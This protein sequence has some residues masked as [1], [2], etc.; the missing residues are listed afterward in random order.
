MDENEQ[1]SRL[2]GWMQR[3]FGGRKVIAGWDW[4]LEKK[5]KHLSRYHSWNQGAYRLKSWLV[6]IAIVLVGLAGLAGLA[7]VGRHHYRHYMEKRGQQQALMF[8]AGGDYRNASLSARQTLTINPN[9]VPACRVQAEMADHNRSPVTLEWLQRIGQI[10]P[11][12]EN[13]L[14]LAAAGLKYQ[15]PPFPLTA[16]ILD[17]LA[18]TATNNATY[19]EV[20]ASFAMYLG[21]LAE[22]EA[23]F[24]KAAA[25]EPK[26]QLF[27][28]NLAVLKMTL[29]NQTEQAQALAILEQ[30]RTDDRLGLA[31]LRALVAGRLLH[32]EMAAAKV[33]SG[34][35]AANPHATMTDRVEYLGILKQLKSDEFDDQLQTVQ[36]QAATNAIAVAELSAWMQANGLLAENLDWLTG[37]PNVLL[38]QM[39][40][41]MALAQ[42]YLQNKQWMKVLNIATQSNWG[43]LEYLR[44]AM[45]SWAWSHLGGGG[46]ADNNWNLALSKAAGNRETLIQLMALADRWQLTQKREALL[47]QMVQNFPEERWA[48]RELEL[49]Y[50]NSGNTPGLRQLYFHLSEKNPAELS[51]QNNVAATSLLLKID[52]LKAR[53]WAAEACARN[54][55]N[56]AVASTYAYALHLQGRDKQG[57]AVLQQL[58]PAELGK[59]AVALYYGVLLAAIGKMDQAR[60]YLQIAQAQGHLL[61]EEQQLLTAAL[62]PDPPPKP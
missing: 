2:E 58:P 46:L 7:R 30:M 44:Y 1:I 37:L 56:P 57:L 3:S 60:L 40:V 32:R 31:A 47:L 9:N 51:Y 17:E 5:Q 36:H 29:T 39:P 12:V 10:E 8:L 61:P 54:P 24:E 13:K 38:D 21:R 52:V 43:N 41:Q 26:N 45:V 62:V 49:L 59:P 55:A 6:F 4:L 35:L 25:L 14:L 18:L 20:A 48:Q 42:G 34:E 16:R 15:K 50:F 23:R 33:Y 53:Q 27:R 22:A 28:M 11:T 19:Q